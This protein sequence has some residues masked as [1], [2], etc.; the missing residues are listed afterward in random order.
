MRE[1]LFEF[2]IIGHM[3]KV[4]AI[5]PVTMTEAVVSGP[6]SAG[7]AALKKLALQKLDYLMKKRDK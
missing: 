4:T 1:I 6:A 2:H 5:E 7:E 3:A